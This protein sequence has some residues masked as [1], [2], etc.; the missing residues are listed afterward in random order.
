MPGWSAN[1]GRMKISG[2]KPAMPSMA[3]PSTPTGRPGKPNIC[4]QSS[5][6]EDDD[7]NFE[8][9]APPPGGQPRPPPPPPPTVPGLAA[10][11]VPPPPPKPL[12]PCG[13][14]L[15]SISIHPREASGVGVGA[16]PEDS[17]SD[18]DRPVPMRKSIMARMGTVDIMAR[19]RES[20]VGSGGRKTSISDAQLPHAPQRRKPKPPL[21][22]PSMSSLRSSVTGSTRTRSRK[23]S[24]PEPELGEGVMDSSQLCLARGA[25]SGLAVMLLWM[26]SAFAVRGMLKESGVVPYTPPSGVVDAIERFINETRRMRNEYSECIREELQVRRAPLTP[27]PPLVPPLAHPC[28]NLDYI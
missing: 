17:S 27:P 26:S 9:G 7:V 20:T 16:H 23:Y 5:S 21:P 18:F 12:S 22:Y 24:N 11:P 1:T 2:M 10:L 13:R 14:H 4:T 25:V 8:M 3:T 19:V 28:S 6:I 15:D